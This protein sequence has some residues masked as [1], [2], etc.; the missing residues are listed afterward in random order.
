METQDTENLYI[1][2]R[3]KLYDAICDGGTTGMFNYL[4]TLISPSAKYTIILA[5]AAKSALDMARLFS[6][7]N[8]VTVDKI[9]A[10]AV[11][12]QNLLELARGI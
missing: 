11:R 3:T 9:T 12:P 5:S 7:E 1:I 6:P 10:S 4:S 8:S 2:L